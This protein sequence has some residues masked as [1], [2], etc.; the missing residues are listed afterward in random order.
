MGLCVCVLSIDFSTEADC[1]VLHSSIVILTTIGDGDITLP[2][3]MNCFTRCWLAIQT[4]TNTIYT[5]YY[6][7]L[8]SF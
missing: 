4:V 1:S 8:K 6:I 7:I 2:T 3:K 5:V